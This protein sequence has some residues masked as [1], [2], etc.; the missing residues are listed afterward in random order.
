V[1]DTNGFALSEDSRKHIN[2]VWV[3]TAH[4]RHALTESLGK[5]RAWRQCTWWGRGQRQS[6]R[7][8]TASLRGMVPW[9][10]RDVVL[11]L[12]RRDTTILG[13]F[14]PVSL[15]G[16]PLRS[17]MLAWTDVWDLLCK[18]HGLRWTCRLIYYSIVESDSIFVMSNYLTTDGLKNFSLLPK[19]PWGL[20][21]VA[22]ATSATWLIRH[23]LLCFL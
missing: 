3:L 12:S 16:Q 22:F 23:W 1:A 15:E 11:L 20:R 10:G 4:W 2:S 5:K 9:P 8:G 13:V 6:Q 14:K 19:A 21:P 17:L 7:L 18:L